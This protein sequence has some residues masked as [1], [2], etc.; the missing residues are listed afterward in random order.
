LQQGATVFNKDPDQIASEIAALSPS[1]QQFYRLGAANALKTQ[2][3][4]T[5][6]GGDE[7]LKLIGNSYRQEQL[8]QVFPNADKMLEAARN[9]STMFRTRREVFGGSDTARRLAEDTG[10]GGG[11]LRP[12]AEAATAAIT[13]EPMLA[14]KSGF[15]ALQALFKGGRITPEVGARIAE[16]LLST[17]PQTARAF[18][19]QAFERTGTPMTRV[20]PIT[21]LL[22]QFQLLPGERRR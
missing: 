8:R 22:D 13:H 17:D 18:A 2:L 5:T 20:Q 14:A 11:V 21:P 3:A 9:E 19:L 6:S 7:A 15:S 4:K 10:G 1:E 12:L 16:Y